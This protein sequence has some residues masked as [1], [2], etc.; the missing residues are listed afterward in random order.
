MNKL[1]G[2]CALAGA[3]LLFA[4]PVLL[5]DDCES[6][7][8]AEGLTLRTARTRNAAPRTGQ[9]TRLHQVPIIDSLDSYVPGASLVIASGQ[10][11]NVDA[12]RARLMLGTL[13]VDYSSLL[14][15]D[16]QL[17]F[18]VGECVRFSGVQP[19]RNGDLLAAAMSLGASSGDS[20][21]KTLDEFISPSLKINDNNA[22]IGTNGIIG[23]GQRE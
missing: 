13:W 18:T 2:H 9:V 19:L 3:L 15:T 12:R 16:P 14:S 1:G 23:G 20:E 22:I 5:A 17:E 6:S 4:P 7:F 21:G 10:I 8:Y 11:A